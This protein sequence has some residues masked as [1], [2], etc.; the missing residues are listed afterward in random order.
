MEGLS[1]VYIGPTRGVRA[2]GYG[3]EALW[4]LWQGRL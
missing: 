1:G 4:N 2:L 3:F